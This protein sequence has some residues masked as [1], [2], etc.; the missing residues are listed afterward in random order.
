MIGRRAWLVT[1]AATG[2]STIFAGEAYGSAWPQ[3]KGHG[4]LIW[5]THAYRAEE[6]FDEQGRRGPLGDQG[7][8][9]SAVIQGWFEAGLTDAWTLVVT[10]PIMRLNYRDRWLQQESTGLGDVQAGIRRSLRGPENGWQVA[11]QVLAKAPAYGASVRPRPGNGQADLE[12]SLLVGRS[13]PVAGRWGYVALES[14]YRKRW[15]RPADQLRGEG[16]VG[17]H[18]SSRVTVAGQ[19]FAIRGLGSL[20]PPE[21]ATNPLIE[22]RFDL[23]KAQVSTIFWLAKGLGFQLGYLRDVAGRNVGAGD[24][25]V[26]GLWQKF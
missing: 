14:G 8:F 23:Y 2:L 3:K 11:A 24:A 25:L 4:I 20:Q 15:G 17:M 22:P 13:F 19:L 26:I 21:R 9:R 12:G 18:L 5:H 6:R 16:A 10:A 7:R 1:L